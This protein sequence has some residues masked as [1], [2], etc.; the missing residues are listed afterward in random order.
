MD[1]AAVVDVVVTFLRLTFEFEVPWEEEGCRN[2]RKR[3]RQCCP[4][5]TSRKGIPN[6]NYRGHGVLI[7]AKECG[8][9]V[10]HERNK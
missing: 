3:E 9:L 6:F 5:K 8:S 7:Y 10:F 4:I 2:K 1:P